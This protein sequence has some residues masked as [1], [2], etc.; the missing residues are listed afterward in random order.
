MPL[1]Y[2]SNASGEVHMVVDLPDTKELP[3]LSFDD[4]PKEMGLDEDP[5]KYPEKED[6]ELGEH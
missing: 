6:P 3:E 1:S 2:V 5:E 4:D